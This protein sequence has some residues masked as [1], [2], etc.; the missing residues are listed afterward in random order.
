MG[1]RASRLPDDPA[2][3]LD[4]P[5]EEAK[6]ALLPRLAH[7]LQTAPGLPA[8]VLVEGALCA[9]LTLDAPKM[10]AYV[11]GPTL[12]RWGQTTDAAL[13]VALGNLREITP[14][15]AFRPLPAAEGVWGFQEGDTHDAARA[16]LVR[17][18]VTPWPRMGAFVG[19]PSRDVAAFVPLPNEAALAPLRGLAFLCA[20]TFRN[21]GNHGI[22]PTPF[23]FDG[24][25]WH[26][27]EAEVT[28]TFVD[29]TL[30][31]PLTDLM[32][33]P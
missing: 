12:R 15:K 31:A 6:G 11:D 25:A 22:S 1:R 4:L 21:A 17:E 13:S 10:M 18:A 26:A 33:G 9:Y 19:V 32:S 2:K 23:W 28:D 27:V 14:P 20:L 30:P 24:K 5:F 29:V 3:V 8:K 16:L 7:P